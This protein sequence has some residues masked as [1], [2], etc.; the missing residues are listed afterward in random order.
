ML[1]EEGKRFCCWLNGYGLFENPEHLNPENHLMLPD[2][3]CWIRN[4]GRFEIDGNNWKMDVG[5]SHHDEEWRMVGD[6]KDFLLENHTFLHEL[7][8]GFQAHLH[9]GLNDSKVQGSFDFEASTIALL[10]S[11]RIAL[12]IN[13]GWPAKKEDPEPGAPLGTPG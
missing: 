7:A 5:I 13:W 8:H 4:Q 3:P 1:D 11:L 9:I 2:V 6:I 12:G 10:S